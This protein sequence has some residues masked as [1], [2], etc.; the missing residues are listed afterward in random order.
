MGGYAVCHWVLRLDFPLQSRVERERIMSSRRRAPSGVS[1]PPPRGQR[2]TQHIALSA[3][4]VSCGRGK[5]PRKPRTTEL[6][7]AISPDRAMGSAAGEHGRARLQNNH[8][9]PAE[10]LRCPTLGF[11]A[12]FLSPPTSV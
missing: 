9:L 11:R 6:P 1:F 3:P 10:N 8:V 4:T 2:P 7:G 12:T 5:T